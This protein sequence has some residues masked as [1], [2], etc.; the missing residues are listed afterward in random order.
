[1]SDKRI[2]F[3]EYFKRKQMR[4]NEHENENLFTIE[5]T[6]VNNFE[7][8]S[9][10]DHYEIVEKLK[11]DLKR[12]QECVDFYANRENW[13]WVNQNSRISLKTDQEMSLNNTHTVAGK[14]AR[15][16]QQQRRE[17]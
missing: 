5:Q 17:G 7:Y 13:S 1:M 12:E 2:F 16:T 6:D 8:M 9:V 10:D 14:L 15:L 3:N 11:A 4:L